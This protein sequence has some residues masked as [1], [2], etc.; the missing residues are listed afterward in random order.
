MITTTSSAALVLAEPVFSDQERMALAGFLA[1]GSG[2]S[3]EAY[4]LDL[5]KAMI[6]GALRH[7]K[8]YPLGPQAGRLEEN[9]HIR[10][11]LPGRG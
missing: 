2:M 3:R 10:S 7:R 11:R 5:W 9:R 1:R 4:A 6:A 8:P